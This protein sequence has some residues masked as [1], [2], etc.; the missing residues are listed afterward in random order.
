MKRA[1]KLTLLVLLSTGSALAS[2]DK[3]GGGVGVVCPSKVGKDRSVK[4]L[5]FVEW[6]GS[7][8]ASFPRSADTVAQRIEQV[9][10]HYASF[11][12]L[13]ME[14]YLTAA[15]N[16]EQNIEWVKELPSTDDFGF[17]KVPEGCH[18]VQLAQQRRDAESGEKR[19][20]IVRQLWNE[21]SDDDKAGLV[22]HEV[23]YQELREIG[24]RNSIQLRSFVAWLVH[25]SSKVVTFTEYDNAILQAGLKGDKSCVP[26]W[27]FAS[28]R[29][30]LCS[31]STYRFDMKSGINNPCDLRV[32]VRAYLYCGIQGNSPRVENGTEIVVT[33][34]YPGQTVLVAQAISGTNVSAANLVYDVENCVER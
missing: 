24:L 33:T 22:L 27:N 4:L 1:L 9:L 16:F 10:L 26:T 19:F 21:M 25:F 5:D 13:R 11:D 17:V 14:R 31:W 15:A 28:Q 8:S 32:Q 6:S 12:R 23:I 7:Y 18:L 2:N 20:K 34:T 29:T 3:G 30:K